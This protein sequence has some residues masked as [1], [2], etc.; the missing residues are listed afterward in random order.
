MSETQELQRGLLQE[1]D[2]RRCAES[3]P[4][5]LEKYWIAVTPQGL[6]HLDAREAQL[7][8]AAMFQNERR[9]IVVKARQIGWTTLI[10]AYLCWLC[11]FKDNQLCLALS[12]REDPEARIIVSMVK[13]GY[14]N[15]PMWMRRRGPRLINNNLTKLTWSNGSQLDSDASK[16]NPARGRTL[17]CLVMDEFGRF[18]NP[19]SAWS[20]ALPATEFGQ[21]FVV[22]NANGWGTFFHTQYMM[23]KEGTSDF[24][25][26]F[27]SWRC[28]GKH[29]DDAWLAR[30]T[31]S[32]TPAQRAAEYPEDDEECWIKA[33]SPRFDNE[34]L[35]SQ[36]W[37]DPRVG[38]MEG[39]RFVVDDTGFLDLYAAPQPGMSY[40]IG[41]DTAGGGESG[42]FACA[43]VLCLNTGQ[44]VAELHGR[45]EPTRLAME[46]DKLGRWY[47]LAKVIPERNRHGIAFIDALRTTFQYPRIYTERRYGV[48]GYHDTDRYGFQT[49]DQTKPLAL[50]R[51]WA[52]LQTGDMVTTSREYLKQMSEYHYLE[53]GTTGGSPHDDRVMA[54]AMATTVLMQEKVTP[55]TP[56]VKETKE[57]VGLG[58]LFG[59]PDV[60]FGQS[61]DDYVM[62]G[63]YA[64]APPKGVTPVR[65]RFQMNAYAGVPRSRYPTSPSTS[66]GRF[67]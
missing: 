21:C 28:G 2:Y 17:A 37:V 54:M 39:G 50:E 24:K 57:E 4:Y 66:H 23:A 43:Q 10:S 1:L 41:V 19:E 38:R 59:Q 33:G 14:D 18:P 42:D 5:F 25:P 8:A 36:Q 47:N 26:A 9:L 6:R 65:R 13:V 46:V 22:G 3:F 30:E 29:R 16:D 45:I 15:L 64:P 58:V 44:H 20:S 53:D 40:T 51:M 7:E 12:R 62:T 27:Y 67:R 48:R 31:S 52:M 55:G 63:A 32:Y 35:L 56:R 60:D 11:F 61:L 34:W 49:T